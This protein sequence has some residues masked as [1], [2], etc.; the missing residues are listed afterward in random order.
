VAVA[1]TSD[2]GTY[3][4]QVWNADGSVTSANAIITL[5]PANTAQSATPP[6]I[7]AQPSGQSVT[8]GAGV[9]LTVSVT[10]TA[11]F[12]YQWT[13]DGAPIAGGSGPAL[14]ISAAQVGDAGTYAVQVANAAGSLTSAPATVTVTVPSTPSGPSINVQPLSQ[15]VS[16]GSSLT[17]FVQVSG[18][19]PLTYQWFRDGLSLG[20]GMGPTLQIPAV[21]ITDAGNYTVKVSNDYG[22]LFS[23]AATVSVV[24]P[25]KI[26]VQPANQSGAI[27]GAATFSVTATGPSLQYQWFR[28]GSV[29]PG[30]TT[31]VLK[32]SGITAAD[33]AS[34]TVTVSNSGGTVTSSAA[35]LS[36]IS[37]P[38]ITKQPLSQTI[39]VGSPLVLS[40]QASGLAPLRFQWFRN[41]V[42]V[43]GATSGTFQIASA[44]MAAAGTYSVVVTNLG[45]AVTSAP[46][47][48]TVLN[49]PVITVGP[50]DQTVVAGGRLTLS[51]TAVGAAPLSYRWFRD[52]TQL[53]QQTG[54][55]LVIN[56]V[57]ANDAGLYMV[58]ISN[59][60]GSV[61]SKPARVTVTVPV[62]QQPPTLVVQPTDTVVA[63]GDTLTLGVE[64]SSDSGVVQYQWY[65]DGA[66]LVNG[67]NSTYVASPVEA[68]D[69]GT[70]T[71]V[72]SNPAGSV[73]SNPAVVTVEG[74]PTITQGPASQTVVLG[75]TVV[76][77]VEASGEGL[78]YQW[79]H[80]GEL[81]A[82]AT[83]A[84]LEFVAPTEAA[85]SYYV[86]VGNSVG[87]VTSAE[88]ILTVVPVSSEPKPVASFNIQMS[89]GSG[90]VLSAVG[91]PGQAYE[92]KSADGLPVTEWTHTATVVAG[93]DGTIQ[94]A[95]S[96][97]TSTKVRIY[98]VIDPT[99]A[100]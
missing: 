7:T 78:V 2:A 54:P 32:I 49:P 29:I 63:V 28:N 79:Y 64:V 75:S 45:G 94:Y 20:A 69:A 56:G 19:A 67:T 81:L 92:I 62:V 70:Y 82:G 73:N 30:A 27:G 47:V 80:N 48:V 8:V 5:S 68:A 25:P 84:S 42:A 46:A 57:A 53:G 61:I 21:T 17:L 55:T 86:T 58:E 31:A 52:G 6:V 96:A 91:T 50:A 1:Q 38:T 97:P 10:G 89:P 24:Q 87:T 4:V 98:R 37:P 99:A 36:L 72:V 60:D 23:A 9:L 88:A 15:T 12:T 65:L 22:S 14:Q 100:Q 3:A 85:G 83:G 77:A 13:K 71:V 51:V 35:N 76:L 33:L 26:T 34:Y 59:G 95:T 40:V 16:L 93:Q 90:L 18:S 43:G 74:A 44:S 39:N 66:A 11:P 41:G